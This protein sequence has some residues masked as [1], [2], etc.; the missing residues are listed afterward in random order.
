[1]HKVD[2]G[3]DS[4]EWHVTVQSDAASTNP[5]VAL[6]SNETSCLSLLCKLGFKLS[7]V[8]DAEG[9]VNSGAVGLL[10]LVDI[11]VLLAFYVVVEGSRF[12]Q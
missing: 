11:E 4:L 1:M 3:I 7:I 2:K 5:I 9:D 12:C 10:N 6:E 8:T